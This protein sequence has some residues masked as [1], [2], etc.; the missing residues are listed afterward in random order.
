MIHRLFISYLKTK[1]HSTQKSKFQFVSI[2]R[3]FSYNYYVLTCTPLA[4]N[5]KGTIIKLTIPIYISTY[6]PLAGSDC[7]P[8][9]VCAP[10]PN[11]NP[12]SPC[13][14]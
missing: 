2:V 13:G 10:H 5:N 14:E 6:H 8:S 7:L 4:G 1:K 12:H 9:P 3:T 11:F